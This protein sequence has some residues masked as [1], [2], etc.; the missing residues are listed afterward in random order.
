MAINFP[1]WVTDETP[2]PVNFLPRAKRL[3]YLFIAIE[4]LRIL[5]N[6]GWKW[7]RDETLDA[8]EQALL[9]DAFPGLWPTRPTEEQVRTWV[10]TWWQP[11]SEALQQTRCQYR[12]AVTP[13]EFS[14]VDL[15]GII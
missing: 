12:R 4:K 15:D 14:Y 5:H 8:D 3:V 6:A 13:G 9:A 11:R 1:T 10:E 2:I 7:F